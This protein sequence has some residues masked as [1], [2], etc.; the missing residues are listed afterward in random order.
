MKKFLLYQLIAEWMGSRDI[1]DA[2]EKKISLFPL[3]GIET[4]YPSLYGSHRAV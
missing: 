1:V 4:I 2:L 3:Q